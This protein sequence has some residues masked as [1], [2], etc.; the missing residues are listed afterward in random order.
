MSES[1][2]YVLYKRLSKMQAGDS[3]PPP[4]LELTE[5]REIICDT[6][7]NL[8]V[9]YTRTYHNVMCEKSGIQGRK[10]NHK[11][12]RHYNSFWYRGSGHKNLASIN[13]NSST[14]SINKKCMFYIMNNF[15]KRTTT[16]TLEEIINDVMRWTRIYRGW[17][18][19]I[20]KLGTTNLMMTLWLTCLPL[21][22]LHF[23]NSKALTPVQQLMKN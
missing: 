16:E 10:V 6:C 5:N 13:S 18:M 2:V 12:D 22:Q 23:P 7:H 20:K 17:T 19:F 21:H 14:A 15:S 1:D 4:I 8:W 3:P 9:K 11:K